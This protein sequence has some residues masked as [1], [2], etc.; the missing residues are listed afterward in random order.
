[1]F[2]RK[3]S[4]GQSLTFK[5]I[6]RRTANQALSHRSASPRK[7]N[8]S[9]QASGINQQEEEEERTRLLNLSV[10]SFLLHTIA[11]SYLHLSCVYL[12]VRRP[13]VAVNRLSHVNRT[14]FVTPTVLRA[15]NALGSS[16][17]IQQ[18]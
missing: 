8:F 11:A 9:W 12:S 18:E 5:G 14:R 7:K 4:R 1:L 2:K 6:I 3:K 15:Y 16:S 10:D 13:D 17:P